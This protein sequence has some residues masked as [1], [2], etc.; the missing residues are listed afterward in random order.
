[1]RFPF[2]LTRSMTSYLLRKRLAGE[3][4]FPMVLMLE[5]SHACNLRCA[6]CGRIREY[7]DTLGQQY[8]SELSA[9]YRK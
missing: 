7:A 6:G 9:H 3:R 5:P 2:S 8:L 4:K 1:M